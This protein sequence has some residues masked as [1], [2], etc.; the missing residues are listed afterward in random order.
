MRAGVYVRP[1]STVQRFGSDTRTLSSEQEGANSIRIYAEDR[2]IKELIKEKKLGMMVLI[3]PKNSTVATVHIVKSTG[4]ISLY[5]CIFA[6]RTRNQTI[7]IPSN[8][9]SRFQSDAAPFQF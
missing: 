4:N 6:V 1:S 7:Y 2:Q 8:V 9:K 5:L 3:A